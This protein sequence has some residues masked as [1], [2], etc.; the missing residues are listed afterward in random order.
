MLA[1]ILTFALTAAVFAVTV[2]SCVS[3]ARS[4]RIPNMH[5]LVIAGCFLMAF[6]ITPQYFGKWWEHLG[7]FAII[8]VIT[9]IM[10]IF[11]MMGG[12]DSKLGSALAL[13]VGL[14]GVVPF[15][16]YM[17]IMGGVIALFSL[18]MKRKKPFANPPAGSWMAEVQAGRN[19]LP[20]GIAIS[21]GAWA[22]MLYT[23]L[24]HNGLHELIKIIH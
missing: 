1:T 17:G 21:F 12:G 11:K 19:A 7:G 5:S 8:F 14:R 4:L 3:D 22:A 24:F 20:Y 9:Y 16:F 23:P 6:L 10:F 2:M 18:W 15:V 13:W